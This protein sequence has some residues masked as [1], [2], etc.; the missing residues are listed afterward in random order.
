MHRHT[1]FVGAV[2]AATVLAALLVGCAG[3]SGPRH[4]DSI[5]IILGHGAA[6]G[7]PRS[8]AALK[9]EELVEDKSGH[10]IDIQILG[11]ETVGSDTEMMVSVAAGTLDMTVN[12]QGP[13]AT[14]VPE[15]ALIGLPFL[16]E[17]SAH[18]HEVVDDPE[19]SGFLAQQAERKGF[20]VLGFWDNGMRDLTNSKREINTP[21]D[22]AGLKIRTPDDTMTI[23]I[24]NQLKANP[25][26][27]AF[28]E[29]YLALKTG[30]VDGQENPVT[31]IK[32]SKLDE[33]QPNLAVTGHKYESNPFVMS[34]SRWERLSPEQ[35][36][37]IQEAANEARDFQR[38]LMA[39]RSTQ[40]YE[41]FEGKLTVTHPD[42]DAFREAT[43]PVYE[44]WKAKYPEFFELIKADA[45]ESRAAHAEGNQ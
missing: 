25:T 26:P 21:E 16:F 3:G 5:R 8:D 34:T 17:N 36:R 2:G 13:F 24:F 33:V 20:H 10:S 7:N 38:S 37:I 28:G 23:S 4:T 22:V 15:A 45:D 35:Q 43:A 29:L 19:V 41:E 31:N 12:S 42:K 6:P 32:S 11:Q 18:A 27:M 40:I 30:A 44:E 14:Y 39:D 1:R 9:F